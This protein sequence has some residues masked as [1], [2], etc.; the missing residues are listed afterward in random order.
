MLWLLRTLMVAVQDGACGS[1]V[2][3]NIPVGKQFL[4]IW[5]AR[6]ER[7]FL[8]AKSGWHKTKLERERQTVLQ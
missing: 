1:H 6:L 8:G 2:A 5:E 4:A 3:P 7:E